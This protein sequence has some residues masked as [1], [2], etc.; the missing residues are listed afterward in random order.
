MGYFAT[1][2]SHLRVAVVWLIWFLGMVAAPGQ[3]STGMPT[4]ST[5]PTSLE[6]VQKGIRSM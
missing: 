3:S 6:N 4:S 5:S 2:E 1:K